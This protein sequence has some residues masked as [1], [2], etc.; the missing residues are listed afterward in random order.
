M[1]KSNQ[2]RP[3]AEQDK[4]EQVNQFDSNECI[5]ENLDDSEQFKN[6]SEQPNHFSFVF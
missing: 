1:I 4:N 5:R 2:K 3:K 6:D